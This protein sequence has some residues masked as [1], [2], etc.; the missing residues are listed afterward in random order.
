MAYN[1]FTLKDVKVRLG[2]SVHEA[3]GI[4][5]AIEPVEVSDNL[6][7]TLRD[8][9][10]LAL[11]FGT[12]KARSEMIIAPILVEVW[13]QRKGEMSLFSGADFNVDPER[14]L[15]GYCDFLLSTSREQ[16][17]IEAPL[18][19]VVEAKKEDLNA[20]T[21]QCLAEMVAV[22]TFNSREGRELPMV[23]GAVTSGSSWRFLR[24]QGTRAEID[25]TEYFLSDLG[26]IVGIFVRM[27]EGRA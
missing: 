21:P 20:G 12:E 5:A 8:T 26:R 2:V 13:R 23:Y 16:L 25:L 18:V 15:V 9:V 3:R 4:F 11:S 1:T 19:A 17:D 22:Q 14:G 10:P 7:T 24:L 27:M 6:Q